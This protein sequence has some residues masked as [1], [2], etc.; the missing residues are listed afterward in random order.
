MRWEKKAMKRKVGLAL[1]G[2]ATILVTLLASGCGYITQIPSGYVG[3]VLN[4]TGF[5]TA[6]L[7]PGQVNLGAR[8][9]LVLL[10]ATSVTVAEKFRAADQSDD[11]Q[12]H[13]IITRDGVPVTIDMYV[14]VA[15]PSDATIMNNIFLLATP[16]G[17]EKPR[18]SKI[19]LQDIYTRFAQLTV[20]G[21][22]REIIAGYDNFQAVTAHYAEINRQVGL[23]VVQVFTDSVVPL[24]LQDAQLSQ[25]LPDPQVWDAEVKKKT[26][27]VQVYTINQVGQA[28]A[29]NPGYQEFL[30]WQS[31]QT[32]AS[33]AAQSGN[34]M[35]I[36]TDGSAPAPGIVVNPQ[37]PRPALSGPVP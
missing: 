28:M 14:R 18:V 6:V 17:T 22:V 5:D 8:G 20:R 9:Y 3:K 19:A 2:F 12:D 11:K 13:R 23:A 15:L 4:P 36:I 29:D 37:Q 34:N 25:V 10:E 35:I 24:K 21:K 30:K 32:I 16:T 31:L 26:A 27:D 7:Q 33:T 1:F